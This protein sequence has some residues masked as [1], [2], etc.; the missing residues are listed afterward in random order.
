M[1]MLRIERGPCGI[2][3][4]TLDRPEARNALCAALVTR[5]T[6]SLAEL[7]D[8]ATVRA[9]LLTGSAGVFCAGADIGEMRAAGAASPEQNE[10]DSRR[11][12][13]MLEVLERQPQPTIAIVNGAAYGGAVGLVAACDIALAARSARFALSE[14]RLGLAPAMISP[15]VI[16]AMGPR[17]AR[18][19]FL[20]GEA[21]DSHTAERIGLVHEVVDDEELQLASAALVD[22]LLAGGPGAQAEI[23][24]LI[25]HVTGRSEP[26]DES[27]MAETARWIARIR[28]G[29]EARE[30]LT[31]FLERRK[32]GWIRDA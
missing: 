14:V 24:R 22:A 31:A 3:T 4:L 8:D 10:A 7:A 21:M 5:L 23:K 28:A 17:Q 16:R 13:K 9:V 18:R 6:E 20:T 19:W 2:A 27:M 26:A 1:A 32:P 25:R 11:F 29:D 15:Y 12:A 30:G